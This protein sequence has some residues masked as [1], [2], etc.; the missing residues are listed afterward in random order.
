MG[1]LFKICAGAISA[2]ILI[3]GGQACRSSNEALA[4][5]AAPTSTSPPQPQDICS[6]SMS[7]SGGPIDDMNGPY[8]HQM[9]V[10]RTSDGLTMRDHRRVLEHASV[11][12]GVRLPDGSIRVYYVN[13]ADGSVW[14]G[15]LS[16]SAFS[17]IGAISINGVSRPQGVVDPDASMVGGRVRLAYLSG[18]G[19]PAAGA[20]RAICLADSQDGVNFIV[21][22]RAF[23][24][25]T[26]ELLTDPSI[27]QL[28]SGTWL[29][30]MSNGNQTVL[31]RSG[32]GLSFS[33]YAR[34]SYGGV[35]EITTLADGRVRLY[36]CASGIES[37]VSSDEGGT[38]M[39]E[40]T[41]M[42]GEPTGTRLVCDPSVVVGTDRFVYKTA[43]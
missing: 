39:R 24:V 35:P 30:A 26:G 7:S 2:G 20:T 4:S 5:P 19:P 31:A 32:D 38:W 3:T 18:F 17:P 21:V 27:I 9:A 42:T 11:P 16:D 37:Y 29:M 22:S 33:E 25:T 15:V 41:V 13:G 43:R 8:Y 1:M 6:P 34:V 12:D 36:V 10:A 40:G 28:R 23:Y 14:V